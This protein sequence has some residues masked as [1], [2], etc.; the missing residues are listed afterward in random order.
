MPL[1]LSRIWLFVRESFPLMSWYK[2]DRYVSYP[3]SVGY[4]M[5]VEFRLLWSCRPKSSWWSH[6]LISSLL[7][8]DG[9]LPYRVGRLPYFFLV[10]SSSSWLASYPTIL[11]IS[12]M[13][14]KAP[15]IMRSDWYIVSGHDMFNRFTKLEH[16]AHS[17]SSEVF[18]EFVFSFFIW[19]ARW[20][21]RA[22]FPTQK[23]YVRL[24][25]LSQDFP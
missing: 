6:G 5:S 12:S 13:N 7:V 24:F 3:I 15:S 25:Y 8:E 19:P 17:L 18:W 14:G 11:H 4:A 23:W 9:T 1:F 10:Y 21:E 20:W 2:D 22:T 16:N